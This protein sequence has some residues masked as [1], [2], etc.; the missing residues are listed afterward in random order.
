[1]R[2]LMTKLIVAAVII[3]AVVGGGCPDGSPVVRFIHGM[4]IVLCNTGGGVGDG[5]D[6]WYTNGNDGVYGAGFGYL[7][8]IEADGIPLAGIRVECHIVNHLDPLDIG[9]DIWDEY[10]PNGER[11]GYVHSVPSGS[12]DRD[13][14]VAITYTNSV[15][16]CVF[17]IGLG[18]PDVGFGG[19]DV[20]YSWPDGSDGV[21]TLVQ[22]R[23]RIMKASGDIIS[24]CYMVFFRSQYQNFWEPFGGIYE[25]SFSSLSQW[26]GW[27]KSLD[28]NSGVAATP[29][30]GPVGEFELLEVEL[31]RKSP[32]SNLLPDK[33]GG[34]LFQAEVIVTFD[35]NC[36]F[37]EG[38]YIIDSNCP[39]IIDPNCFWADIVNIF[40]DANCPGYMIDQDCLDY[41]DPN[42][43]WIPDPNCLVTDPNCYVLDPDWPLV[44]GPMI[45]D[46]NCY[47]YFDPNDV[48][49]PV[50]GLPIS[51]EGWEYVSGAW[52]K[53]H[54]YY[55]WWYVDGVVATWIS[56]ID[57]PDEVTLVMDLSYPYSFVC[58]FEVEEIASVQTFQHT[59]TVISI[60]S[61]GQKVSQLPIELYVYY[62]SG[63]LVYLATDFILPMEFPEQQG[64]YY[65]SRGNSY[66]AIYVPQGGHL[67]I[68]K[69]NF[70]GD[71]NFDGEV[72]NEDYGLFAARWS[73]SVFE[74]IGD[75][76]YAY[77]L[78][79]DADHDGQTDIS[80]LMWFSDNWLEV[81]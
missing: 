48:I 79:Y 58:V 41:P 65:D 43:P 32:Y 27:A 81:R 59:G 80:D 75:P 5:L 49:P 6:V 38:S 18:D 54:P 39:L 1:M 21:S 61:T 73:K 33:S 51:G 78:K 63:N 28:K 19:Q 55:G 37:I 29:N 71:F 3:M 57:N 67:E 40:P 42:C 23:F 4:D 34:V 52:E 9:E 46:P 76:N 11:Y 14:G 25:A 64:E 15:G 26:N 62:I 68:V 74:P 70:Y 60:N 69:D 16:E 17:L 50:P 45:P 10:A 66:A 72:N 8:R 22:V 47:T 44:P 30:L 13:D 56:D 77:D 53:W 31:A 35:P 24:E 12:W 36:V 2:N 7:C 20:G